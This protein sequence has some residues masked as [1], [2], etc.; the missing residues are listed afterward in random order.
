MESSRGFQGLG[1]QG[2]R[3][4][5]P[6]V[7]PDKVPMRILD[8]GVCGTDREICSFEYGT[9]PAGLAHL[10]IGHE[11]LAEIV[12]VGSAVSGLRWGTS[13]CPWCAGPAP[14]TTAGPAAPGARTSASPGTSA[15][16]ASRKPT[17]S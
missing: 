1:G 5:S 9:P 17:A 7:G 13:S 14:T 4:V 2:G 10:V 12:E 15:S 6:L 11:S 3:A 8:V 16:A